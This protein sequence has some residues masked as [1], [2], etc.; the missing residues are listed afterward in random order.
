MIRR[1]SWICR[2]AME[3]SPEFV[4]Y[5]RRCVTTR[6]SLACVSIIAVAVLLGA[7]APAACDGGEGLDSSAPDSYQSCV[8]AGGTVDGPEESRCTTASG[9]SFMQ[10]KE[11]VRSACKDLCGDGACQEIV[12][13]AVG[14]PCAESPKKCP[15]DCRQ[16]PGDAAVN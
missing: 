8:K 6:G 7:I 11:T 4:A 9:K 1:K 14:C 2:F 3:N 12:C 15:E 10:S 13:M 16:E 5:S